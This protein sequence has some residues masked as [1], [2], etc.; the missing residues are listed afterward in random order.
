MGPSFT[1]TYS[2]LI[3]TVGL[4]SIGGGGLLGVMTGGPSFTTSS[5]TGTIGSLSG[6]GG[7][8]GVISTGG[9]CFISLLTDIVGSS[10]PTAGPSSSTTISFGGGGF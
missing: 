4:S 7:G 3:G 6:G 5:L 9:P 10:S 2:L 1:F 8:L